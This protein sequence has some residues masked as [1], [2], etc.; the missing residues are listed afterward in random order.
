MKER[1]SF[2][3]FSKSLK[4]FLFTSNIQ[5]LLISDLLFAFS[6][7][8]IPEIFNTNLSHLFFD[9][10]QNN[11]SEFTTRE[12]KFF[13]WF[14]TQKLLLN[15]GFKDFWY[16]KINRSQKYIFL[17]QNIIIMIE[18]QLSRRIMK[19]IKCH[20]PPP[21]LLPRNLNN[22]PFFYFKDLSQS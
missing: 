8:C 3:I 21:P 14:G 20:T 15:V 1:N 16:T 2:T 4:Y 17:T 12:R 9:W 7:F 19:Y 5:N 6:I 10:V 11:L 22:Y 18:Y 13:S